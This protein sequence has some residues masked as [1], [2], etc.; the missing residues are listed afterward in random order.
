MASQCVLALLVFLSLW[1]CQ[2][3]YDKKEWWQ[4]AIMYQIY[5]RSFK[6][7][8]GDGV[9]D[10]KGITEKLDYIQDLGI[11]SIWIQ[12]FYPSGGADM[13][14]DITDFVKVDPLFGTLADFDEL[15]AESHKRNIR[16]FLDYVPNHSSDEHDWFIKSLANIEPYNDYYIWREGKGVNKTDPPNNWVSVFGQSA[17]TYHDKR[18]KF[19]FHQFNPKQ[20]DLNFRSAKLQEAM[21]D[22][23]RFWLDRGIDGWRID[24]IKHLY[25][26]EQLEDEAYLPGRNGSLIYS[27]L[28]H[29]KTVDLPE[30]YEQLVVWRALLDEYKNKTGKERVMIV[31]SY[32]DINN[33]MQYFRY[34]GAPAA[35]YPFNFELV[36]TTN[37]IKRNLN[38]TS[39]DTTLHRWLDNLPEGET[40]NWVY[41]NHDNPRIN[42]KLGAE[43]GDAFLIMSLLLPGVGVTYYGDEIGMYGAI[44]RSD[45]RRDPNNAGGDRIDETRDPERSPMQWD[46]SKHAGF[47]TAQD[48]W[49]PVNSNYW[50]LNVKAQKEAD[51]SHLKLYKRLAALR[52]RDTFVY[53]DLATHVLNKEFVLAITR[54]LKGNDTYI[55]VINF[56]TRIEEVNLNGILTNVTDALYV[57]APSLSS[58]YKVGQRVVAN[59]A[60]NATEAISLR[61]KA[62]VVL[63]QTADGKPY[64]DKIDPHHEHDHCH[65][66]D[67]NSASRST[68]GLFG[69]VGLLSLL[70]ISA[71][72]YC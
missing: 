47:S 57:V 60:V 24:A 53:G 11:E 28:V 54:T 9:G 45:Q 30:V 69:T 23:L 22:V 12:P 44:V 3:C 40:S 68:V 1:G 19:Y 65:H 2:L 63:I 64:V 33:T 20:P 14:Y 26:S 38:A 4:T 16:V 13:G 72:S 25:E 18:K 35:H 41:D 31:E 58:G 15:V 46:N 48:T 50:Y 42:D 21:R 59:P 5:P 61:P 7:S 52:R 37:A 32:T 55:S 17:W 56:N 67:H 29:D 34:K 70:V 39:I 10:L 62:S 6:D 66:H 36:G 51:Y 27:D 49:L 71:R 8:N 43:L